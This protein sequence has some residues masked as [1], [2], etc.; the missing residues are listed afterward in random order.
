VGAL[1]LVDQGPPGVDKPPIKRWAY[2]KSR[3]RLYV[4]TGRL[5]YA[6][7]F[8]LRIFINR[9]VLRRVGSPIVRAEQHVKVTHRLAHRAYRGGRVAQDMTLILSDD[10]VALTDKSWY[11]RWSEVTD[12]RLTIRQVGGTHANLLVE[13]F[14]RQ[15][16]VQIGQALDT[17][18]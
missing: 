9:A 3:L 18:A 17:D 10:S 12:G 11:A 4:R 7:V 2:L 15:L 6:V 16:A 1:V 5:R 13:P 8:K 14:V